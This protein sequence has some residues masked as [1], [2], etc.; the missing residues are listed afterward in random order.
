MTTTFNFHR[1]ALSV[2]L[3]ITSFILQAQTPKRSFDSKK[4]TAVSQTGLLA[5][6]KT[7]TGSP[8]PTPRIAP[9]QLNQSPFSAFTLQKGKQLRKEQAAEIVTSHETGLPIFITTPIAQ[10]ARLEVISDKMAACQ[11]YLDQ[12]KH[13][14]KVENTSDFHLQRIVSDDE[15]KSHVHLTQTF[16]GVKIHGAEVIVHLNERGHGEA[17]N[18][19]YQLVNKKT[20]TNPTFIESQAFNIA[21]DDL[22]KKTKVR[23]LSETEK[24]LLD[25]EK[26]LTELVLL[27]ET[28]QSKRHVLTYHFSIRPNLLELWEYFIDAS[29]GA[30]KDHYKNTCH[31]DGP[32]V[33]VAQDLQGN[34]RNIGT[35]QEGSNYLL[36]D[37]SKDMFNAATQTG[38]IHTLN[39]NFSTTANVQVTTIS[40][41]T[42]T[43]DKTAVSAHYNAEVAYDYFRKYHNRK[44]IDGKGGNIY[45]IINITDEDGS[46]LDNAFWNGKAMFYGNGNVGFE[47]LAR[48]IDVGGHEMTHGVV[49]NTA[50]LVYKGESGAI[51]E[52]LA[53]IFGCMMDSTDWLIG[54]DVV[55][56]SVFRSGALRSLQNPHNGGSSLN[57][58]GFQPMHM[59]EKYQGTQ[60]NGGVHVNSGIPNHAFYLL[61]MA[62]GKNKAAKV[63]Y[64]AL[65]E[66]LTQNSQ[67]IDLRL[68]VVKA[69][70]DL[71]GDGS[72]E[73]KQAGSAF[74][75][76]GIGNGSSTTTTTTIP[77]NP[78]TE[79]LLVYDV[80][81][82]YDGGLY[83]TSPTGDNPKELT[84]KILGNK[85]SVPDNGS[86]AVF[87]GTDQRIYQVS[88]DPS[89]PSAPTVLHD[90]NIWS[91]VAISKDGQ[92]IAAITKFQDTSIYVFDL[93]ADTYRRFKLYNPTFTEGVKTAGPIYADGLE[94]DYTGEYL[95]YDCFN[96]LKNDL[97]DDL[98]YWDI[99][100][101]KVWDK[102]LNRYSDGSIFKLFSDLDEGESIGNPAFA[103]NSPNILA[104][105]YQNTLED[106]N[107]V[108]GFDIER[109][110]LKLIS[111]NNQL[112]WPTYNKTD[113]KLAF[114]TNDSEVESVYSVDLEEDKISSVDGSASLLAS[115][116]KWPVYYTIGSRKL[117]QGLA[118]DPE[119]ETL[120]TLYPNPVQNELFISTRDNRAENV[121]VE[122]TSSLG[123]R[124]LKTQMLGTAPIDVSQLQPGVYTLH[125][126]TSN[127]SRVC[128]FVKTY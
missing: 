52:S 106:Y 21:L 39:A 4:H 36:V 25:Y 73:V 43:W 45:S 104:F 95:V 18:G 107:W 63:F 99:N 26:P 83:R 86:I 3:G 35:Y 6:T 12:I 84:E 76:V 64:K 70:K 100:F 119:K 85:P 28:K 109:N 5:T 13:H 77:T 11:R 79:Y 2:L 37:A 112:G 41:T 101:I 54:E 14:L 57:D 89:A 75:A 65:T 71:Y 66:S 87:V 110:E 55:K 51:N 61:A 82:Q 29:T 42:N 111:E 124:L 20:K 98:E 31:A 10:N 32:R 69:A 53:D 94:W 117:P 7:I 8:S 115:Y 92:R 103:K 125:V 27:E 91:N 118:N 97:G 102:T 67:F 121:S 108:I 9:F 78:G 128:T 50:N 1:T 56:T 122:I 34:N 49:Q 47:P 105:D 120:L 46:G 123:Q 93:K 15:G 90:D 127:W 40:S 38:I 62:I 17:F 114:T 113:T 58:N 116:A 33:A 22:Q 126:S 68:S 59:N 88:I 23:N 72:N 48:S 74:D 81:D 44:S 24:E 60:D 96:N 80:D 16:Q 19:R 30:I